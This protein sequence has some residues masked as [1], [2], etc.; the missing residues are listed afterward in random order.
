MMLIPAAGF[1]ETLALYWRLLLPVALLVGG[2]V[3]VSVAW[4]LGWFHF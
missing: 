4:T 2:V 1:L 3:L